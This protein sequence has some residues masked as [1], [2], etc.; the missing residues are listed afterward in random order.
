MCNFG[1]RYCQPKTI[2]SEC[3]CGEECK[4]CI[5][6]KKKYK[7]IDCKCLWFMTEEERKKAFPNGMVKNGVLHSKN[8]LTLTLETL[9]DCGKCVVCPNLHCY[10]PTGVCGSTH[11]Q[12]SLTRRTELC[13]FKNALP[14]NYRVTLTSSLY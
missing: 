13:F 4:S 3:Q 5:A 1:C 9:S 8:C 14:K 11:S 7:Q 2:F 10:S 12:P 6:Y